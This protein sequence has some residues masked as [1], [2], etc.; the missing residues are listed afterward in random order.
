M[1]IDRFLMAMVAI[2]GGLLVVSGF[3]VAFVGLNA[4]DYNT[5]ADRGPLIVICI[6]GAL[7]ISVGTL[8]IAATMIGEGIW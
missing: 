1:D 4:Y 8:I 3:A 5:K 7:L 2:T 6:T